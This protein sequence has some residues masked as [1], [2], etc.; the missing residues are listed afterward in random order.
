MAADV[1]PPPPSRA[2]RIW[3]AVL[4]S[5][6]I[7]VFVGLCFIARKFEEIF[8]ELEMSALPAPTEL[9]VAVGRLVRSPA[10]LVVVGAAGVTLAV[11]GLRGRLDARLRGL[12]KINVLGVLGLMAFYS[13]SLYLPIVR[14][15]HALKSE[16]RNNPKSPPVRYNIHV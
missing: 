13:L 15:Q 2:L 7:V 14:I 11:L 12:I 6:T 9:C 10:G 5:V 1:A 16:S 3:Y 4:Q 8:K